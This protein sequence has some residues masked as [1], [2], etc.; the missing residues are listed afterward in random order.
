MRALLFATLLGGFVAGCGPEQDEEAATYTKFEGVY[1]ITE[2]VRYPDACEPGGTEV[3][4]DDASPYWVAYVVT[5]KVPDV[6]LHAHGCSSVERCRSI[7]RDVQDDGQLDSGSYFDF[8]KYEY[9]RVSSDGAI[10]GVGVTLVG[11]ID[12]SCRLLLEESS[13]AVR[14]EAVDFRARYREGTDYEP[15]A[16]GTCSARDDLS[17]EWREWTDHPCTAYE[18]SRTRR[19]ETL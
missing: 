2:A 18:V 3:T 10:D 9:S 16:D 15:D 8:A 19:V 12:G 4:R 17:A 14:G 6:Q 5:R 13:I 7:A 11:V 1:E